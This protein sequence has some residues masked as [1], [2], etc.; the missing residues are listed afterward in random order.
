MPRC[1]LTGLLE[2]MRTNMNCLTPSCSCRS[3]GRMRRSAARG[4]VR[5]VAGTPMGDV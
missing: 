4:F 3:A 2:K 1:E 5:E